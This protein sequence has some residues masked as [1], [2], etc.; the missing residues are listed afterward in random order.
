MRSGILQALLIIASMAAHAPWAAAMDVAITFDDLPGGGSELQSVLDTLAQRGWKGVPGFVNGGQISP[1]NGAARNLERWV[2]S[3]QRLGNHTFSH[4]DLWRMSTEAYLDDLRRNEDVLAS[5]S[6]ERQSWKIFRYPFLFE[7]RSGHEYRQVRAALSAAGYRV[8]Q[9]T[10]DPYDWAWDGAF[11]RCRAAGDAAGAAAAQAAFVRD[12]LAQM[13][14]AEQAAQ[15]MFGRPIT[16]ILLLHIRSLAAATLDQLLD[17]FVAAGARFVPIE[18]A[19]ADPAYRVEAA[20]SGPVN[21]TFFRQLM[22]AYPSYGISA[23]PPHPMDT[24]DTFCAAHAV[25]AP[26]P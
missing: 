26:A 19:L 3:G 8:A 4:A 18:A 24:M 21:G 16:H 6:G 10:I 11:N 22:R 12:A 9:V 25:A 23:P 15:A 17:A 7:G 5:A 2:E 13:R 14:W 20:S 1:D